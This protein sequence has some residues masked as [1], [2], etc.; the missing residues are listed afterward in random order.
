MAT[1]GGGDSISITS[2]STIAIL[3]PDEPTLVDYYHQLINGLLN[4]FVNSSSSFTTELVY[5]F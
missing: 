4:R 2:G 3:Q 5:K 1:I